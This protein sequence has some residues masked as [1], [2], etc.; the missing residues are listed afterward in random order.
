VEE[1]VKGRGRECE[2][3]RGREEECERE[4]SQGIK[5]GLSEIHGWLTET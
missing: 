2:R 1:R 5:F 4:R 3:R